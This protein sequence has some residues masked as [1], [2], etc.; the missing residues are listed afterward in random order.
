MKEIF[1]HSALLLKNYWILKNSNLVLF[2]LIL[3]IGKL[4]IRVSRTWLKTKEM[5][6]V[7][8]AIKIN[9]LIFNLPKTA[10]PKGLFRL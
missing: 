10:L 9:M 6:Q 8:S 1:Q 4:R 7:K 5:Q 3:N 2:V